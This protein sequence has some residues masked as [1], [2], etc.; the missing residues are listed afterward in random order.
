M[1]KS[2]LVLV[3]LLVVGA[4]AFAEDVK[5]TWTVSGSAYAIIGYDLN[6]S[7]GGIRNSQSFDFNFAFFPTQTFAKGSD[8][9]LYGMI[10]VADVHFGIINGLW[11]AKN[12]T[13]VDY[14][15]TFADDVKNGGG[16]I[17][18]KV[19]YDPFYVLVSKGL[20]DMRFNYAANTDGYSDVNFFG[21]ATL[22]PTAGT[23]AL[24][25]AS[26][27]I[28]ARVTVLS[29]GAEANIPAT[30]QGDKADPSAFFK[31]PVG[32]TD[33]VTARVVNS[34]TWAYGLWVT[35]NPIA[36]LGVDLKGI[37]QTSTLASVVDYAGFGGKLTVKPVDMISLVVGADAYSDLAD[38]F[39]VDVAP[40]LTLNLGDDALT[41]SMYYSNYP[42]TVVLPL[43]P[44]T[45]SE[46]DV[47]VKFVEADADKGY[48]PGV[49]ATVSFGLN[50][51]VPATGYDMTWTLDVLAN[52]TMGG[53]KPYA[54]FKMSPNTAATDQQIKVNAGVVFTGIANTAITLDYIAT[55]LTNKEP[56]TWN[57]KGIISLKTK[58]SY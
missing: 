33:A 20:D 55:D 1:K 50:N 43:V 16:T 39:Y 35:A 15:S 31:A 26:T 3:V 21:L 13:E 18:A 51:I 41:A 48:I 5:P 7:G 42:Y 17:T 22:Y 52:Y 40:A 24:G 57:D 14:Y 37:L 10:Q 54:E 49:G 23:M 56:G 19:V 6:S 9:K 29:A 53:W 8:Q 58:I 25:Y 27:M 46:F 45:A 4:L 11:D 2:L 30:A 32:H 28:S 12:A 47:A 38:L 36:M 34:G 44:K